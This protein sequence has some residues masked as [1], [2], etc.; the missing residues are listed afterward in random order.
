MLTCIKSWKD[1]SITV[2]NAKQISHAAEAVSRLNSECQYSQMQIKKSTYIRYS[3]RSLGAI[4]PR[5]TK[6][7]VSISSFHDQTPACARIADFFVSVLNT[8]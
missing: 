4:R 5:G 1:G 7:P 8:Y 6:L 2:L 3:G